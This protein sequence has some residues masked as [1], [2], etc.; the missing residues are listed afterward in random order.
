MR[1]AYLILAHENPAHLEK[2]VEALAAP[3]D[4]IF[5]HLDAKSDDSRFRRLSS[6]RFCARRVPVYWGDFSQV[7]AILVLLQ[8]AVR[9]GFDRYVL[10]S[11][12]D[13]PVQP[14]SYIRGF[15][16]S[17][18]ATEFINI[19]SMPSRAA[20]K[21]LSLLT[22]FRHRATT[23][24]FRRALRSGLV[25][26][27]ALSRQ[28]DPA[29]GLGGLQPFAGSTWW[30]VT[31]PATKFILDFTAA[32]TRFVRFFHNVTCPDEI[33]FHTILGNSPFSTRMQPSVTYADW[34]DGG[35]SPAYIDGRHLELFRAPAPL[36]QSGAEGT[37]EYLF[38]RK[39]SDRRPD[40]AL[41]VDRIIRARA[42]SINAEQE[43]TCKRS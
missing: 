37:G 32:R 10:L 1:I 5:I 38:A 25:R 27:G 14:M 15:L 13:Y 16:Q 42:G 23:S 29:R 6:A 28:R 8:D 26:A 24:P 30:A 21:P 17:H 19:V 39:F 2:L 33:F 35:D 20:G 34:S 43:A 12:S 22:K 11:G 40:I 41:E 31:H 36:I 7:E 9:V 4:A 3:S 18:P